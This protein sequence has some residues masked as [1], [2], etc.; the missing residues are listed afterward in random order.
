[1]VFLGLIIAIVV[2]PLVILLA[3]IDKDMDGY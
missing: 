3:T 2:L 1:M